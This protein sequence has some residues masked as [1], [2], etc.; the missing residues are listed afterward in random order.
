MNYSLSILYTDVSSYLVP[1]QFNTISNWIISNLNCRFSKDMT[2]DMLTYTVHASVSTVY[3]TI[4]RWTLW[5]HCACLLHD[6]R[7]VLMSRPLSHLET[8]QLA[9][10]PVQSCV[11]CGPALATCLTSASCAAGPGCKIP[12]CLLYSHNCQRLSCQDITTFRED[13]WC[14]SISST[15]L[16]R[17]PANWQYILC[18]VSP[19]TPPTSS[20]SPRL[21]YL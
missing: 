15:S 13:Y 20:V 2:K 5:T 18:Q 3:S 9:S 21:P 10:C 8:I 6:L 4:D 19:M 12:L 14:N 11:C 1:F 16:C 7:T 17:P